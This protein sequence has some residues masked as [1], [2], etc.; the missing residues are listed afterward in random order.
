MNFLKAITEH[1]FSIFDTICIGVISV[2]FSTTVI[3]EIENGNILSIL[4]WFLGIIILSLISS[5]LERLAKGKI[6]ENSD[7]GA[8]R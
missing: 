3:P 4:L 6:H 5:G 8:C 1:K 7:S 2:I